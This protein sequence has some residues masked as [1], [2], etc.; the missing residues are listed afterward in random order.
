MKRPD[1]NR[2]ILKLLRERHELT[3][4]DACMLFQISPATA[5]RAFVAIV[6]SGKAEKTWG[7]LR[8]L[9]TQ[10][11]SMVPSGTREGL[12]AE[13]K[14]RIAAKAATLC[15]DGDIIFIDGGT[16]TLRLASWLAN[17]SL[18]IVTNSLLIAH[19]IDRQSRGPGGAEV[20]VTGGYLYP[21]SGLLVGPEA[22]ASL[23][24]YRADVAFLSV[25]GLGA[26]GASNNHHLVVEIERMML[27]RAERTILLADHSKFG[28]RDLVP[29]CSWNEVSVVVTDSEPTGELRTQ[30]GKRLVVATPEQ[31][32]SQYRNLSLKSP[33]H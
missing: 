29:E 12:F 28:R 1:R 19:E 17:R 15:K 33:S 27:A 24:K 5:R 6:E 13:E 8:T 3:V 25:G 31:S 7:G 22:T 14:S 23:Q 20:F 11:A 30:I 9:R 32:E 16:T 2:E 26:E 10:P 4:E 21:L 18:R